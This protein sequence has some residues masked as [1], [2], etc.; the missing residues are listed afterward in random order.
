[1]KL[2][3]THI[4]SLMMQ[5]LSVP[6]M[7]FSHASC[8]ALW[9]AVPVPLTFVFIHPSFDMCRPGVTTSAEDLIIPPLQPVRCSE[10]SS[11]HS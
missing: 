6:I 7:H 11:S 2:Q 9:G 4:S 5:C 1:M 10:S 3:K 8:V